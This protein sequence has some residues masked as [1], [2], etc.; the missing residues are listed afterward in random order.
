M[1]GDGNTECGSFVRVACPFTI[2]E[3]RREETVVAKI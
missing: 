1:S 3:H 2:R